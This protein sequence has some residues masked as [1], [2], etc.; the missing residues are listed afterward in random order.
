MAFLNLGTK[1]D[2]EFDIIGRNLSHFKSNSKFVIVQIQYMADSIVCDPIK[3]HVM[4]FVFWNI[5]K[6]EKYEK[7]IFWN[8]IPFP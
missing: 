4:Y 8:K 3:Q 2:L 5:I 7:K 6:N 1:F